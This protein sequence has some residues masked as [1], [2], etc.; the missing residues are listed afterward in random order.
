MRYITDAESLSQA[1]QSRASRY[2]LNKV[3]KMVHR[4][5]IA[6]ALLLCSSIGA[7]AYGTL[8]ES[9]VLV[10]YNSAVD[11]HVVQDIGLQGDGLTIFNYYKTLHPNVIGL[12]LNDATLDRKSTRLNSSHSS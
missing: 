4:K 1:T 9:Q 11:Q 7:H 12:D 10:V 8:A 3:A 6:G 5:H 2:R